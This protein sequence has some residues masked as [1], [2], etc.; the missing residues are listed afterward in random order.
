MPQ[1]QDDNKGADAMKQA[2]TPGPL[3]QGDIVRG[4]NGQIETVKTANPDFVVL[5]SG[6]GYLPSLVTFIGRP[7]ADGWMPWSGGENPVPGQRV[8]VKSRW[9]PEVVVG[10]QPSDGLSWSDIIAFRLAPTAPVEASGSDDPLREHVRAMQRMATAYLVPEDYTDRNGDVTFHGT[11]T[12]SREYKYDQAGR[13]A[14]AFAN[15][16]IYMLDGPEE[17]AAMSALRPQPSGET[18]EGIYVA[19][20]ASVPAR[21]EMWR[22][23]RAGGAP[24]ISTWIDEDG[25]G[26]S[27][28]LGELWERILREVTSAERLILYVEPDDFPLKGAFIEVGMALAAGVPVFVVSPGVAL[29]A[30]S[31]RP[32][33][34]WALH[35]LVTLCQ[36]MG[37]ALHG[38]KP[39]TTPARAEAQDEGAAGEPVGWVS[40]ESLAGLVKGDA[41][42]VW[43]TRKPN[44]DEAPLYA[45]P[46]P[47]PAADADRVR[48]SL[49]WNAEDW[50]VTRCD[51]EDAYED[52]TQGE[53]RGVA[54]IGNAH[55][56]DPIYAVRIDIDTTGDGEADDYEIKTFPTKEE[57]DA[58]LAEALKSTAAKE[59][60]KS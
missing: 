36:T 60:E 18:R 4:P 40:K 26:Q 37:D 41:A 12:N 14:K 27:H 24:I 48:P 56:F 44:A 13:R 31:L 11:D 1:D 9:V 35:P 23:L 8:E 6:N 57:A 34:S 5:A 7:D 21:G 2:P 52:A 33:G 20:R 43:P 28:D 50:E 46:S 30:R 59:G 3:L 51:L 54:K 58:Y 32:L 47:T 42:L 38:A 19:S 10:L 17:R 15:D 53:M 22:S 55:E 45:H 39:A 29:E 25:E 49:W 16:M